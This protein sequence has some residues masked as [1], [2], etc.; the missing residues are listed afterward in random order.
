[1]NKIKYRALRT[2][3]RTNGDNCRTWYAPG[4][5]ERQL[6]QR[7]IDLRDTSD[8]LRVKDGY[9]AQD[10]RDGYWPNCYWRMVA[11]KHALALY[12]TA[13]YGDCAKPR[14]IKL[15]KYP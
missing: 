2:L 4:S 14:R 12:A 13:Q 7:L 8:L 11:G 1:M 6:L 10:K 9:V 5:Q 15:T 3:W